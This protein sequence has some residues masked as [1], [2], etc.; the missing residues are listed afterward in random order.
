MTLV[1]KYIRHCLK[2][3]LFQDYLP[4]INILLVKY[5]VSCMSLGLYNMR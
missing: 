5:F 1:D 3:I 2:H 4:L